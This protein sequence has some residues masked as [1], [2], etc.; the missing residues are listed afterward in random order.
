MVFSSTI[1]LFFFLPLVLVVYFLTGTK[2][3]NSILLLAS[4]F[5][6]AWGENIFVLLMLFSIGLNYLFGLSI[7]KSQEAG[8]TGKIALT[9]A[10]AANLGLLAFFKYCNFAVEN[11]NRLLLF[12][13]QQ[14]IQISDVHLPIGISFFTFQAMSYVVDVYRKEAKVQKNPINIALYISLFPQLIAGPIV[15]YHDIANQITNRVVRSPDVVAGIQRFIIGL[16]KKVLIA[17]VMGRTADYIFSLPAETIPPYLAWMGAISYSLQ[18]YYDFSGYSD[19]AIGLGR[20]FGF[21]FLENFNYPYFASSIKDFWRR[22]HISLS[23][24][25][26]D[27]LY[28]PLGGSRKSTA[29]TYVN[30]IL[31]F[32]LC[33]LWHGASWTFVVWGLYHGSFLIIERWRPV[34]RL[35]QILPRAVVHMYVLLVVIVGWVFFRAESFSY[36]L[37]YLKAMVTFSTPS[38][39]NSQLFLNMNQEYYLIFVLAIVG[40]T[41]TTK[42]LYAYLERSLRSGTGAASIG[43]TV[44]VAGEFFAL[45]GIFLYSIASIMGGAY[46]PFLYFRF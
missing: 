26:R 11:I 45:G 43:Q 5:F 35:L 9:L 19:M 33:G 38:M 8:K 6:Y 32:F 24:W 31:V 42:N 20:I 14:P 4:L 17:N 36:A 30:L 2:G 22:W 25:F 7:G 44:V 28:I 21:K 3:R 15:R 41:P 27:Y 13:Q 40:A 12:M 37:G 34:T 1:F 10:I 39:Y 18:I 29:R 16:G 23:S 46:N